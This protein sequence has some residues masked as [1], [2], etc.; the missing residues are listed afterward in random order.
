MELCCYYGEG[1]A[2]GSALD[3]GLAGRRVD[4]EV[5]IAILC[6]CNGGPCM[7]GGS[8]MEN[9]LVGLCRYRKPDGS[10]DCCC[11]DCLLECAV[12]FVHLLLPLT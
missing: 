8:E 2:V 6:D 5:D 7:D 3:G 11:Q 1:V 12:K 4:G 10:D 9:S